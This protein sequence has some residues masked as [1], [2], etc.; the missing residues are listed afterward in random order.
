MTQQTRQLILLRHGKSDWE[1]DFASDHERPVAKRGIRAAQ[2][3][4]K[5]LSQASQT[6]DAVISSSA[7]RAKTTAELACAAGAWNCPIRITPELYEASPEQAL[8]V[9]QAVS[10]DIGTLLLVGH[11]PTWSELTAALIG[12][13][14]V[15]V[16]TAAMVCIGFDVGSWRTVQFASGQLK[17]LLPP[18]FFTEGSFNFS[19]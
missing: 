5:L 16:P 15:S 9:I 10:N 18:K 14:T 1:A 12:G 2:V 3:M 6:P 13:G 7:V 17:W 11:Q 8:A 4:G 19:E